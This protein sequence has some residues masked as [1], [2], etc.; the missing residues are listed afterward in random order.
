MDISR[1]NTALRPYRHLLN[2]NIP[3]NVVYALPSTLQYLDKNINYEIK[4]QKSRFY[5]RFLRKKVVTIPLFHEYFGNNTDT[6][7]IPRVKEIFR[8]KVVDIKENKLK[9][10]NYKC[11][12]K[13]GACGKLLS[14]WN[15]SFGIYCDC[16]NAEESQVHI[17]Y[18]CS[19]TK[20]IW[21]RISK[22]CVWYSPKC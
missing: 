21:Q 15:Q 11:L 17:I 20:I 5:Y 2:N 19:E 3:S 7:R 8:S 6:S 1:L 18:N 12:Y 13:V 22:Y 10:F 9:E 4:D 14:K 16:C